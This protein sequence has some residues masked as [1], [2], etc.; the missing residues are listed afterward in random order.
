[1]RTAAVR[2]RSS[3][4]AATTAWSRPPT[5]PGRALGRSSARPATV[6]GGA[7]VTE[8]PF[9][10]DYTVTSLSYVVSLLPPALVRDLRP[11]T[12][13][14]T[15]SIPQGPYFAPRARRPLPA[16]ARRPGQAPRRRSRSS[17]TRDADADRALGR[18]DWPA[19]PTCSARCWRTIPPKVGS[20][21]PADLAAPG[22]A[23]AGGC[24]ASTSARRSTSPGCSPTSIAD[25]LEDCFESDAD[26]R[27]ARRSAASSAPGPGRASAGTAYVMVH[28]HVGDLGDGKLGALGLPARR[29]GRGHAA[30]WPRPPGPSAPRSAPSA[31]VAAHRRTRDGRA[32]G[33][34]AGGRRGARRA[35]RRHDRAPA[36][37]RSC[38]LVDRDRPAGRLR[39]RHRALEHPQRHRQG[40]PGRRP[41]AGVH[42][43]AR[44]STREVHGG[45]IVLAESPRRRRG[46]LPGRG[47]RPAGGAAVR[48]RLHPVGVRR[49]A[50]AAEGHHIVSMFTQWVPHTWAGEPHRRGAGGATPTAWSAR[51]ERGRARVHRLGPA[52]AGHRAAT[53]W[54]TS[55]AWSAATSSTAS[56]R[57]ARCSTPARPPATPT[58]A[59]PVA[60]L[61]QAGSATHG[62]GGVTGIPGRNVVRQV[63]ADRR[64]RAL[65]AAAGRS[66]DPRPSPG[67]G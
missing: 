60:G 29:H 53:R 10:P 1:M 43:A 44:S 5:W 36:R 34:V 51:M 14:A 25:L 27:R 45:T 31:P 61:Y 49:L 47:R 9:G 6:V 17:P 35:D 24:A 66:R 50:G 38:E 16:A 15:T 28:H 48:R 19:W 33:V 57:P 59:R 46:R 13:T 55:T 64:R 56:C 7:A 4:A 8:Q 26:A 21:R 39:R 22:P 32:T 3:S 11:A 67:S 2:R 58:C 42:L 23:A 37:S 18:L 62:G 63:L 40:Q 41:A 65:A 20:R 52:P 30:R 54:S 12:G